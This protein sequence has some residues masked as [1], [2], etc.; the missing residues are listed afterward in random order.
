MKVILLKADEAET[1]EEGSGKSWY[2]LYL[3]LSVGALSCAG[4]GLAYLF[5]NYSGC[6]TGMFFIIVTL[7]CGVLTTFLSLLNSVNKGLLTPSI[8][9]AYSV[10]MCWCMS[11]CM[12]ALSRALT[13]TP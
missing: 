1:N 6:S 10:F 13:M 3:I 4:L 11:V 5:M 8:M 9:F 12:S 7:I 2:A